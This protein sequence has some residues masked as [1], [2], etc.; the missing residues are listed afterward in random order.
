MDK[1]KNPIA[2]AIEKPSTYPG[3]V[4]SFFRPTEDSVLGEQDD[5][6]NGV[7][8]LREV[9][10]ESSFTAEEATNAFAALFAQYAAKEKVKT[11][12]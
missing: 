7:E 11:D 4:S 3:D 5:L 6:A 2:Q 10:A 12:G 1:A 8:A 9:C